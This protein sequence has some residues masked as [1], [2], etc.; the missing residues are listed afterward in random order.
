VVLSPEPFFT[1]SPT[2]L[3]LEGGVVKR[4]LLVLAV[5]AASANAQTIDTRA[6]SAGTLIATSGNAGQS[7]QAPDGMPILTD[8][9]FFLEG[10]SAE[11]YDFQTILYAFN[12]VSLVGDPLFTSAVRTSVAPYLP[13]EES[14]ATGGLA[15]A[16]GQSY[17]AI[18]QRM[19]GT[20]GLVSSYYIAS[21]YPDGQTFFAQS[22]PTDLRTVPL[23]PLP[24]EMAFVAH[25]TQAQVIATPEPASLFLL[26]PALVAVFGITR[27]HGRGV[28]EQ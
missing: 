28:R 8:F 21:T 4:F 19:S 7:F 17:I 14:F 6:G 12:G 27:R 3:K 15:L 5:A 20:G 10:Y 23:V 9:S 22:N 2:P 25:F 1:V 11:A 26:A 16:P 18:A 13:R 24:G